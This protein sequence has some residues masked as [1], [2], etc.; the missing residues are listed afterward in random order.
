[1]R[2]LTTKLLFAIISAAFAL[3]ALG[4][5][6]FAWFT[7]TNEAEISQFDAQITAGEGIEIS[8]DNANF[9][10]TIPDSVIKAKIDTMNLELKDLTS[11]DGISLMELDGDEVAFLTTPG[12]N[13][14]SY[15]QFDLWVRSPKAGTTVYLKSVSLDSKQR[16]STTQSLE[17]PTAWPTDAIFVNAKG[18]LVVP[19]EDE[20]TFTSA[21]PTLGIPTLTFVE[22]D[23]FVSYK[24]LQYLLEGG[25]IYST[26]TY[27]AEDAVRLSITKVDATTETL[28]VAYEKP[29]DDTNTVLGDSIIDEGMVD[30]FN[31]KNF[32][33]L[34][35]E[36]DDLIFEAES[37]EED[38]FYQFK[39]V[40]TKTDL[41]NPYELVELTTANLAVRLRIRIWIE[42]WDPD[43]F[44]AILKQV[45]QT[46]I[47]FSSTNA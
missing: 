42:G 39:P 26:A 10:T 6:T 21:I 44:N 2:K 17:D 14:N 34:L 36:L 12:T 37:D 47:V 15:I 9:Y 46:Q 19:Y 27:Y 3:V 41:T 24:N 30:Y 40:D 20:T 43:T 25:V 45:I 1:M 4:T 7:L 28:I 18:Q 22:G 23:T 5:T 35:E 31:N 29:E 13:K 32:R 33:D 11:K 16:N 38:P 8:L